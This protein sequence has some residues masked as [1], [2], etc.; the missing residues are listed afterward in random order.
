LDSVEA[1]VQF[2]RELKLII[3]TGRGLDLIP[4]AENNATIIQLG[5]TQRDVIDVIL[6]LSVVDYCAG[7]KPDLDRPGEVW[8]FGKDID[9]CEVYIKLKIGEVGK[10]R[11]AKCISFHQAD[12]SLRHPYRR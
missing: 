5:L 3:T 11:I 4:R 1:V 9:G 2:L 8:E 7:P 6:A 12:Y 10:T